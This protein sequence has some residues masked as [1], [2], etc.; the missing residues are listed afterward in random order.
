MIFPLGD[1]VNGF[2]QVKQKRTPAIVGVLFILTNC[3]IT[4]DFLA[5]M[6]YNKN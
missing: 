5:T 1:R 2:C 6:V 3:K 4:L